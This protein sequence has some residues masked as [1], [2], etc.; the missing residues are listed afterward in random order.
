[1]PSGIAITAQLNSIYL[2]TVTLA[3][4]HIWSKTRPIPDGCSKASIPPIKIKNAMF[5]LYYGD[6]S[7]FSF[8]K[9]YGLKSKD[10]FTIYR[11]FGLEATHCIKDYD[12]EK[13]VPGTQTTFLRR[14]PLMNKDSELVFRKDLSEID[15]IL[16]WTKKKNVGNWII[17]DCVIRSMLIEYRLFGI[18]MF[19]KKYRLIKAAYEERGGL[20]TLSPHHRDYVIQ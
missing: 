12:I 2:E 3:C 6:D 14:Q 13:E 20:F 11:K 9:H 16:S 4:L 19:E 8:P 5:A 15:D 1:M 10:L 17:L 18:D 7:W